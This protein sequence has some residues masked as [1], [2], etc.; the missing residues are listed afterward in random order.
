MMLGSRFGSL[1]KEREREKMMEIRPFDRSRLHSS[2]TFA[3]VKE[4]HSISAV[5]L[6]KI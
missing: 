2:A 1:E 6:I 5:D 3:S 4:N